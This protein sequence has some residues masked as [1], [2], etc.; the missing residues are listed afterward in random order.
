MDPLAQLRDECA[1]MREEVMETMKAKQEIQL[2]LLQ[3]VEKL[4]ERIEHQREEKSKLQARLIDAQQL[5][6][7]REEERE[8]VEQ[9][10]W[11]RICEER[12][13]LKQLETE[14]TD[15]LVTRRTEADRLK[16]QIEYDWESHLQLIQQLHSKS[17]SQGQVVCE[18]HE[19][20]EKCMRHNEQVLQS[21][22]CETDGGFLD[23]PCMA[24]IYTPSCQL[25]ERRLEESGAELQRFQQRADEE[26][27]VIQD[28]RDE[29]ERRV[30]EC[31]DALEDHEHALAVVRASQAAIQQH[32]EAASRDGDLEEVG[33]R[34]PDGTHPTQKEELEAAIDLVKNL[35]GAMK[36]IEGQECELRRLPN[37]CR[38][39]EQQEIE[40]VELAERECEKVIAEKNQ[41]TQKKQE[42]EARHEFLKKEKAAESDLKKKRK[43]E[44]EKKEELERLKAQNDGLY[45]DLEAAQR[46]SCLFASKAPS[47]FSSLQ[48][49]QAGM[50]QREK[51]RN[52]AKPQGEDANA[53]ARRSPDETELPE[54]EVALASAS[55]EGPCTDRRQHGPPLEED[56]WKVEQSFCVCPVGAE[57]WLQPGEWADL[58]TLEAENLAGEK[59]TSRRDAV[60]A[61]N[62]DPDRPTDT[63]YLV[64]ED[65]HWWCIYENGKR[66][67]AA[68]R[69]QRYISEADRQDEL[70]VVPS[71]G[72][73]RSGRALP[74]GRHPQTEAEELP[75]ETE[76]PG[77]SALPT[78]PAAAVE[79]EE[80]RH[81]SNEEVENESELDWL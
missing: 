77:K 28:K 69:M 5:I 52:R 7:Q 63:H 73:D 17:E 43:R 41:A 10:L 49:S 47:S 60:D 51:R 59:M 23:R 54:D 68:K 21:A 11:N 3:N 30:K 61:L 67:V 80:V 58:H 31:C 14:L 20:R 38:E 56:Q 48:P 1:A 64:R 2:E 34:L 33:F 75:P 65:N 36:F 18:L 45:Q 16:R 9:D 76:T 55:A 24:S 70:S 81:R 29:Q 40:A 6:A 25:A 39:R 66:D 22:L 27:H 79:Q 12:S 57:R 74:G 78:M 44:A 8:R 26:K 32:I 72:D 46:R 53:S 71:L 62:A 4:Q 50:S 15:D 42:F 37:W 35:H 19:A 13:A